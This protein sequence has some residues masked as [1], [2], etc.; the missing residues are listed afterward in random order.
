MFH[1]SDFFG[2]EE[3]YVLSNEVIHKD[4]EQS[5]SFVLCL[6]VADLLFCVSFDQIKS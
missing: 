1:V 6:D 3:D 4:G 5:C 2:E